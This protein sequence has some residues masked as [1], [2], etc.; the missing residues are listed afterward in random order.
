MKKLLNKK[1][2]ILTLLKGNT[3]IITK[4]SLVFNKN[5]YYFSSKGL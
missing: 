4:P 5:F 3:I 2:I 1:F